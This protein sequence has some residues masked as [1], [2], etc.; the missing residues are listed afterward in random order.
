MR[1]LHQPPARPVTPA[2]SHLPLLP[3]LLPVLQADEPAG[4]PALLPLHPGAPSF[5]CAL[6]SAHPGPIFP[7]FL[8]IKLFYLSQTDAVSVSSHVTS[9]PLPSP[10]AVQVHAHRSLVS[11]IGL[12]MALKASFSKKSLALL[13]IIGSSKPDNQFPWTKCQAQLLHLAK[14]LLT[15]TGGGGGKRKGHDGLRHRASPPRTEVGHTLHNLQC[16]CS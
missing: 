1:A 3:F 2:S 4:W 5:P 12:E 8:S 15:D 6:S 11:A 9:L 16:L 14:P 7:S 10:P 13:S